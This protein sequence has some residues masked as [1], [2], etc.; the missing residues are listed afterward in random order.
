MKKDKKLN[1]PI[2]FFISKLLV[3]PVAYFKWGY[4]Y[5]DKYK[6]AKDEKVCVI[7][8]HQTD[9]DPILI[10]L[11]F[12]KFLRCL[13]TDNIFA[14]KFTSKLLR[15]IGVIPKRKGIVDLRSNMEML[16]ATQK[17]DSLLFFPEGNRSYAEFQFY[18]SNRLP[19]IIKKFET[20]LI[21]FNIHGGFGRF[22]RIGNKPRKGKFYGEI[23]KVLR[24]EEYKDMPDDELFEI[25]QNNLKTFDYQ[26]G[27]KYLS[28]QKAEY[29][30]R[31]FF[32]CPKCHKTQTI[33]SKGN[34]L[35]CSN[36]D[37]EVEYKE[38]LSLESKDPSIKYHRLL[39]W[40]NDQIDY[41]NKT[42]FSKMNQI[43]IDHNVTLK[44]SNPYDKCII[45]TKHSEMI[46]TNKELIFN[47]RKFE[48]KDIKIASPVSG[49]KLCFTI[50]DNN[51][52]VRGDKRFNALKYVLLF[53]KLDTE[54]KL[55][56]NDNYF[57]L[58][59]EEQQ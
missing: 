35:K 41:I 6:I 13:A 26:L 45:I 49:R 40:Y 44:L 51:Y 39:D 3:R 55:S 4:R 32:Y 30:E 17:G 36:C 16:N 24:Y 27:E 9:Y 47:N 38:D 1:H 28:N 33:Y 10:H 29:F 37:L 52:V 50:G 42:D 56:K 34:Y 58:I 31:E 12:N 48:I 15:Y 43:F 5:K 19:K 14:G 46:L 57:T 21:I 8:N 11:S 23:K 2:L 25:I 22:P 7:S 59:K 53:N 18:V 54:M 20:T